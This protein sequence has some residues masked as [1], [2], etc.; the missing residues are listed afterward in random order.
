LIPFIGPV[1]APVLG[2]TAATIYAVENDFY[3]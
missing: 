1:I 3:E 2:A